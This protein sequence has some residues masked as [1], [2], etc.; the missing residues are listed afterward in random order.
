[1]MTSGWTLT[2][3]GLPPTPTSMD[4][5]PGKM[6]TRLTRQT[7]LAAWITWREVGIRAAAR[8]EEDIFGGRYLC[9]R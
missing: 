7:L 1:M 6:S 5:Q 3:C 8:E 4:L 9:L 2:Q